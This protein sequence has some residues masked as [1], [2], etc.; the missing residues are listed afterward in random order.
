L[1][2][3]D[4]DRVW[5]VERL[6]TANG[7]PMGLQRAYLPYGRFAE[8]GSLLVDNVSLYQI[9]AQH[10]QVHPVRAVETYSAV[11]LSDAEA[12]MLE[13]VSG[14]PAFAVERTTWASDGAIIEYVRSVM[15]SDKYHYSVE[16]QRTQS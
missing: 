1:P 5:V 7:E 6:R 14:C 4:D 8:L 3:G 13:Q 11:A 9:L 15:R 10:Y 12:A 2:N 16:L